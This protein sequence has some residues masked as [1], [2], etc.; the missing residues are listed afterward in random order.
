MRS[1]VTQTPYHNSR[2]LRCNRLR[3]KQ[4]PSCREDGRGQNCHGKSFNG[5]FR[6]ECLNMEVWYGLAETTTISEIWRQ[7]YNHERPNSS[8]RYQ[9]PAE[10]AATWRPVSGTME[11]SLQQ[12]MS[13]SG[14]PGG[15]HKG[16]A[17]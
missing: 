17:Q 6:D 9:T 14:L 13:L 7:H 15:S 11:Q 1:S 8:L 4:E 12:P 16:V 5:K 3:L 2:C 10:F